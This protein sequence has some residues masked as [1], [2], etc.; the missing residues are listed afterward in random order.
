MKC[1]NCGAPLSMTQKFCSNCGAPNEQSNQ[2]IADM[3]KYQKKFTST[4]KEVIKNSKWFIKYITPLTVLAFC[5]IIS[6]IIR[7]GCESNW[8]YR[9]TD[10]AKEHYNNTHREEINERMN[11][12]LEN[13]EYYALY[14]INAERD[15]F[16]FEDRVNDPHHFA[17]RNFYQLSSSYSDL[18][19]SIMV[20]YDG[21]YSESSYDSEM[22]RA[23]GSIVSIEYAL[24][25]STLNKKNAKESEQPIQYMTESYHT[26]LKVYCNFTDDDISNLADKDRIAVLSLLVRRMLNEDI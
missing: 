16:L 18:R 21:L 13:K 25:G 14:A 6:A 12:L 10:Y 24:H 3:D 1:K 23:A 15:Q 7:S 8:S 17:W 4:R 22:N 11:Q 2:H 20:Y 19:E 9:M 5:V 26:F